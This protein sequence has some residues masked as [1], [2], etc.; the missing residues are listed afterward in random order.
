MVKE[1]KYSKNTEQA[2]IQ[3]AAILKEVAAEVTLDEYTRPLQEINISI[4]IGNLYEMPTLSIDKV[5]ALNVNKEDGE[6]L[7]K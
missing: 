7:M 5:Y 2:I 3:A 6:S 4:N 1:L